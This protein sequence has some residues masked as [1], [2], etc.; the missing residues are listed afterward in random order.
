MSCNNSQQCRDAKYARERRYS[1][2]ESLYDEGI[3]DNIRAGWQCYPDNKV[4]YVEGFGCQNNKLW[5]M[6]RLLAIIGLVIFI[7]NQIF[8]GEL[9]DMNTG[10]G[11]HGYGRGNPRIIELSLPD[12]TESINPN[13]M[14]TPNLT[15][16]IGQEAKFGFV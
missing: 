13:L 6:L 15:E 5:K 16:L 11:R 1:T 2:Q 8:G 14:R 10:M 4:D 7:L 12:L 9:F 3:D